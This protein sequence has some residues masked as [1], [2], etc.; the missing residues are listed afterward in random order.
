[1]IHVNRWLLPLAA[2]PLLLL[3]A[4]PLFALLGAATPTGLMAGWQHPAFAP[5]MLLSA[6]TTLVS[7]A[8]V[9]VAGTPL[10]WWLARGPVRQTQVV[11]WL[12][13]VPIVL[14]PAVVGIA[15]LHALGRNGIIGQV[16]GAAGAQ[17]AF[18]GVAVVLAQVTISAPFYVRS[19]SAAFRN[20]NPDLLLVARTLGHRPAAVFM[21]VALPMALP[22]LVSGAGLAWGRSLGEFGATL[23]FAGNLAGTTQ[24]MPLAIYATLESDVQAA[25]ALALVL[26]AAS[27]LLLFGLRQTAGRAKH[28][29]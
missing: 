25:L 21:K 28:A 15:L 14:P 6:Q 5:A 27:V 24:T 9:L 20:L 22:G 29:G 3:F 8:V 7:L 26:A 23:L 19:A 16:V 18:T 12:V 1:M 17:V 2:L 4:L 13:D 10:A 11:A